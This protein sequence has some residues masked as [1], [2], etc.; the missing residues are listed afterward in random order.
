MPLVFITVAAALKS[1]PPT[2]ELAAMILGANWWNTFWFVTFPMIRLGVVVGAILAFAFSFDELILALFLASPGTRTLPLLLW[3]ELRV[4]MTPIIA[5]AATVVLSLS[6]L[7]LG[8]AAWI[9]RRGRRRTG[10]EA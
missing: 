7:L 2:Y 6:V 8:A 10:A 5:A 1:Y 9:Q 4:Y 3:T